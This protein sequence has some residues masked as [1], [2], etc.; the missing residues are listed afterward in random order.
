[1]ARR[2]A[3]HNEETDVSYNRYGYDTA[4]WYRARGIALAESGPI[5]D[6]PESRG[7]SILRRGSDSRCIRDRAAFS[8]SSRPDG[9][10]MIDFGFAALLALIALGV[11]KRLLDWLGQTPEHPL[12]A[13]ALAL[14]L[15]MGAAALACSPWVSWVA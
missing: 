6:G 5:P 4:A 15:G 7:V 10:P 12:D 14:P 3:A 11:G 13:A 2:F 8:H 1:M 9:V